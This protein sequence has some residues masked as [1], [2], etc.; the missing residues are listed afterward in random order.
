MTF[1]RA[2][3]AQEPGKHYGAITAKAMAVLEVLLWGFHNARNARYCPTRPIDSN[4]RN[5]GAAY[6]KVK[7]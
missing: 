5:V 6:D 3:A 2:D 4:V 1:A 7:S